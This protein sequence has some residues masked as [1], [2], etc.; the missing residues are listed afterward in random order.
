M[1]S[2]AYLPLAAESLRHRTSSVTD[3]NLKSS[4]HLIC[5][6]I[7]IGWRYILHW[8]VTSIPVGNNQ[9]LWFHIGWIFRILFCFSMTKSAPFSLYGRSWFCTG[10]V[11][12]RPARAFLWSTRGFP[13]QWHD[14]HHVCSSS[15][16]SRKLILTLAISRGPSATHKCQITD[17]LCLFIPKRMPVHANRRQVIYVWHAA[18]TQRMLQFRLRDMVLSLYEFDLLNMRE[19]RPD[20]PSF[21]DHMY[22]QLLSCIQERGS[23]LPSASCWPLF[24]TDMSRFTLPRHSSC[25]F[26]SAAL[27]CFC[28]VLGIANEGIGKL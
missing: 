10:E 2:L 18:H 21:S 13:L 11:V 9:T 8:F 17:L 14:L 5:Q 24:T 22:Y 19:R 3:V 28:V 20:D 15:K 6:M 1:S 7:P 26:P 12:G 25:L 23:N 27:I 16:H 4:L